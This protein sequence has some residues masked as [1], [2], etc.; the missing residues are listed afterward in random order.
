MTIADFKKQMT[1]NWISNDTVK[2]LYGLSPNLTF[3]DQFSTVSLENIIF[4]IVATSMWIMQGLFNQHQTETSNTISE[5][6]PHTARWYRNKALAFQYGFDLYEDSDKFNNENYSLEEIEKSKVVRYSAVTESQNESRLIIKIAGEISGE[7]MPIS[8]SQKE[9]FTAYMDEI[10]D[11]GVPITIINYLPDLL[12]LNITIK[13]DPLVLDAQG[14]AIVPINGDIK[15][16]DTAISQFLRKLP[17]NGEL[18]IDDLES[19]IKQVK[20]VLDICI[21][22]A[23]SSWFVP[24]VNDYGQ[25]QGIYMS[26]I[27]ES[28]YFTTKDKTGSYLVEVKYVV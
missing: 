5:L 18:I 10:K 21:D 4:T 17:F 24:N 12:Y 22:N 25:A 14:Y 15:P 3:E 23:A 26:K 27:P 20:G 16:I 28:G 13:R 11:A 7:L 6:K 8:E 19:F 1:D 9:S 2:E